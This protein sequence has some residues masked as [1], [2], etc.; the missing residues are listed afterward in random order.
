M[1][2]EPLALSTIHYPLISRHSAPSFFCSP[3]LSASSASVIAA[4]CAGKI[5]PINFLP[6]PVSDRME[7]LASSGLTLRADQSLLLQIARDHRQVST[8]GQDLLRDLG[9]RHGAEVIQRLQHSELRQR[10]A[11]AVELA[12]RVSAQRVRRAHDAAIRQ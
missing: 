9:E 10:Q 8:G 3:G 11:G 6:L 4:A 1:I 5:S 2:H 12:R 7:T